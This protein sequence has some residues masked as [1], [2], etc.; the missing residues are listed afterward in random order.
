VKFGIHRGPTILVNLNGRIDYFG[1]TVN[2]AARIQG[3]AA[4]NELVFSSE[5][6]TSCAV[7]DALLRDEGADLREE[8]ITLKGIESG[9]TVFRF[10]NARALSDQMESI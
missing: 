7:A 10:A 2:K 5:V 8:R 3:T 1:S 9:Q 6:R 4:P